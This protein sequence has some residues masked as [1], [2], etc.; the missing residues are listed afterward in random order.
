MTATRRRNAGLVR[1]LSVPL[2]VRGGD[3]MIGRDSGE[4]VCHIHQLCTRYVRWSMPIYSSA[5]R[6]RYMHRSCPTKS[7]GDRWWPHHT[8]LFL[9]TDDWSP[10]RFL[11]NL[12]LMAVDELH[13]YADLFGRYPVSKS[14]TSFGADAP[15]ATSHK[16]SGG[17]GG[18]VRQSA[19]STSHSRIILGLDSRNTR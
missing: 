4:R 1:L 10:R 11:G 7:S 19:V 8:S 16:S 17:F 2:F 14:I 9:T 12:K 15:Q 18:S 3:D 6:T 5:S 13:Y